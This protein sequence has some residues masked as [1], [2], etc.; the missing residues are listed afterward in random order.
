MTSIKVPRALRDRLASRARSAH[1]TLAGALERALD[2]SE[3]QEFWA[4]VRATNAA[5]PEDALASVALR[6]NLGDADDDALG[7][8]GW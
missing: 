1:T 8:G 3:E 7:T 6:D 2:E 4:A 5:A